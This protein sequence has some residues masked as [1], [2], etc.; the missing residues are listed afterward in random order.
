MDIADL[1]DLPADEARHAFLGCCAST[2]WSKRM[3]DRRPFTD[4]DELLAAART[5]W[6]ALGP[7]DQSEAFAAHPRIGETAIGN[8]RHSTWSRR[9]QSGA[10]DAGEG[11]AEQL[12]D[13]NRQYER[14]FGRVYLVFAAG[15][16]ASEMLALCQERLDNDVDTEY[17]IASAEQEKIT[18]LRLRRLVG[19]D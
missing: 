13:C 12:A 18:D 14:R 2:A 9:E 8:D 1:N 4:P 16:S 15:K 10:A 6:Q 5:E 11:L 7:T 3:A 17:R 19:I